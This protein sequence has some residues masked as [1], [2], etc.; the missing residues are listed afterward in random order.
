[1]TSNVTRKESL[2]L[3]YLTDNK[4]IRIIQADEG[5][6]TVVLNKSTCK[7]KISSLLE[8]GAYE[9]LH[10]DPTS[11]IERKIRKLLTKNKT[12]IPAALKHKLTPYHSKSPHIYDELP[13]IHKL[14]IPVRPAV[15]SPDSPC[16]ALADYLHKSLSHLAA[17]TDSSMKNSEHFIKLIQEISL[18]NKVCLVSSDV[19]SLFT[20]VPLEVIIRNRLNKDPSFLEHSPLQVEDIMELL[21]ICLTI[22]TSSLRINSI[23]K[24]RVWQWETHY[25]QWSVIYLWNTLRKQHWIQ[26]TTN[27]I[28]GSDTST[29]LSWYGHMDQQ[30]YSKFFTI[31]TALGLPSNS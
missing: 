8:S 23:S 9:I 28:N 22:T 26:Q 14:D 19:V 18:Q 17:N 16:Y 27:P 30:D 15:S 4:E 6:Y 5:N 31:S 20:N 29:T 2:A 13:K 10:K 24:K 7:E 3:K 1:L 25:L 11:Q 12:A 21:D